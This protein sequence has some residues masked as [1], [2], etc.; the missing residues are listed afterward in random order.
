MEARVNSTQEAHKDWAAMKDNL[1]K[2]ERQD[3]EMVMQ[4]VAMLAQRQAFMECYHG[5]AE[6]PVA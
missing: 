4:T 3:L 6:K 1:E 5:N 2:L